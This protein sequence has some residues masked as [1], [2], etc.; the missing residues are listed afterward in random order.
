MTPEQK[1]QN[2]ASK[3]MMRDLIL[4]RYARRKCSTC[5]GTSRATYLDTVTRLPYAGVC[6]C[7]IARF[8]R[9][10][11]MYMQLNR[12]QPELQTL[13]GGRKVSVPVRPRLGEFLEAYNWTPWIMEHVKMPVDV[14]TPGADTT[15][16]TPA[17]APAST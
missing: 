9:K 12:L 16:T 5:F 17:E 2:E 15:V 1:E 7:T 4:P 14:A 13:P 8:E 10:N 6:T 3:R 11:M